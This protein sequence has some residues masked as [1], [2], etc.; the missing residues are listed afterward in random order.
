[1]SHDHWH[2]GPK[3]VIDERSE[4]PFGPP[5]LIEGEDQAAYDDFLASISA[6]VQ[7]RDF[8][9]KMWVRDVVDLSWETR[10]M[11]RLKASLLTSHP[12]RGLRQVADSSPKC[13]SAA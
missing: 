8:L 3:H 12:S 10:R 5:P 7:P 9:E 4:H 11:R 1:M 13:N 2:G 6:A